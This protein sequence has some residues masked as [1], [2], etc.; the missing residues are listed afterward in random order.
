MLA[1]LRDAGHG[2][3]LVTS[4]SRGSVSLSLA[5]TGLD[6]FF[7][8]SVTSDDVTHGK[9][10]PAPFLYCLERFSLGPGT[11]LVVEDAP[12]G[13]A[14]ARA[15]GLP[16]VAVNNPAAA[17]L[18]DLYFPSLPDLTIWAIQQRR[19]QGASL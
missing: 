9:P 1:A 8:G 19:G 3:Y 15:A 5:A 12:S 13:I 16:V 11:A 6:G 2:L 10:H 14:S 4:G 17:P 7:S 18:A